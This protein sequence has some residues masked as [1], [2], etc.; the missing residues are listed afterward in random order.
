MDSPEK[1]EIF[2]VVVPSRSLILVKEGKFWYFTTQQITGIRIPL[3][4]E[5]AEQMSTAFLHTLEEED[6]IYRH[7]L[8]FRWLQFW[9]KRRK[10]RELSKYQYNS[11]RK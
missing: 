4:P 7:S 6:W 10:N 1:W 3:P 11:S 2:R 9:Y 8:Q 5:L